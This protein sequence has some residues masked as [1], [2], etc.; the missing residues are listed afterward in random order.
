MTGTADTNDR[1]TPRW[2]F[3][4]CEARYAPFTLDVA[5]IAENALCSRWLG[6]GSPYGEDGLTAT[7]ITDAHWRPDTCWGNVPYGPPGTIERWIAKARHERDLHGA[8]TLLLLPSDTS[9][10][11]Y[12]DVRRTELIEHVPFRLGFEAPDGSTKGNSAL[13]ASVL[14][15]V[16]PHLHTQ[17]VPRRRRETRQEMLL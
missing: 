7:W 1:R 13:F 10:R 4:Q 8:R 9:T 14:V 11:W 2:F 16:A 3:E 6:P 5:A 12:H 17:R 15:W